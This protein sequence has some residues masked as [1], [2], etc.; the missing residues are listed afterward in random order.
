MANEQC[1]FKNNPSG[2]R[3]RFYCA[4]HNIECVEASSP[5]ESVPI[6]RSAICP[7]SGE[8]AGYT[9]PDT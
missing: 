5:T 4:T 7:V 1:E 6:R 9:G 3:S 8:L 2:E